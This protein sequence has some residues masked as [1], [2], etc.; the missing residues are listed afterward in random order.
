[1]WILKQRYAATKQR[2]RKRPEKD[3]VSKKRSPMTYIFPQRGLTPPEV[4]TT[5]HQHHQ[6]KSPWMVRFHHLHNKNQTFLT[7]KIW[8]DTSYS[9]QEDLKMGLILCLLLKF[10]AHFK[11]SHIVTQ[12]GLELW[13]N[14]LFQFSISSDYRGETS[15]HGLECTF[16]IL[17]PTY[18]AQKP[19]LSGKMSKIKYVTFK[20][21]IAHLN[22]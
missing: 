11:R 22:F 1:M 16:L 19:C 21:F 4:S 9:K 13:K 14:L 18:N 17:Y 10:L 2:M 5:S 20:H 3:T 6:R 12:A 15:T 8:V 7:G